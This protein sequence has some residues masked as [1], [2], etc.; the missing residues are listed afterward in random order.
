MGVVDMYR[1]MAAGV[2]NWVRAQ[3]ELFYC[4]DSNAGQ[5]AAGS[6]KTPQSGLC[7][8]VISQNAAGQANKPQNIAVCLGND[9]GGNTCAVCAEDPSGFG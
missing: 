4:E 6:R 1:S 2:L 9:A 3:V 7:W 5:S 8:S